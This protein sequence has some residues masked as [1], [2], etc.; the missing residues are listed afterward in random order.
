MTANTSPEILVVELPDEQATAALGVALA[1]VVESGDAIL[2]DGDLGAGKTV[3]ARG[4]IQA[5]VGEDVEVPSPT[6]TLVQ[7]Y[8][9]SGFTVHH[10]DLYRLEHPDELL[11]IGIEDALADGVS[12]FEWPD[13]LGPWQPRDALIVRLRVAD[14]AR[15]AEIE[16]SPTWRDRLTSLARSGTLSRPESL[17]KT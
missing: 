8:D 10:F 11:E 12:L 9:A 1:A 5:A 15:V 3:L 16:I 14:D 6:F 7:D 13:R 4:L 17:R 2:L